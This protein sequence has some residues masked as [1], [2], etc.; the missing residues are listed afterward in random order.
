MLWNIL[1]MIWNTGLFVFVLFET[2]INYK[3]IEGL[4]FLIYC[5]N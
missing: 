5:N 2:K 1:S 4:R 3:Y